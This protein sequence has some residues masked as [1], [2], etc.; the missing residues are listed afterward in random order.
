MKPRYDK[1]VNKAAE[2]LRQFGVNLS[3]LDILNSFP[4]VRVFSSDINQADGLESWDAFSCVREKN[5][6]MQYIVIYNNQLSPFILNRVLARELGH[7]YLKHDG[8]VSEDIWSEEANCFAY[9]FICP[10]YTLRS[11]KNRKINYRP[12]HSSQLW[13]MKCV[14]VFDSMDH[15]KKYV[16]EEGN[17]FNRFI[18]KKGIEYNSRDVEV[19]DRS[20]FD[21]V[22][23]WKNCRK[24]VLDGRTVGY[25]GE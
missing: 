9:H 21:H 14:R 22:S 12:A 2:A 23:G 16:V 5:G 11:T 19:S 3:A 13:A 25:C 7:I 10:E 8:N 1:A 15:L 18:G 4:N 24:V 17:K 6:S 20:Y